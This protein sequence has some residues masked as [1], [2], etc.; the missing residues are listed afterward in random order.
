MYVTSNRGRGGEDPAMMEVE[1]D[2]QDL[3]QTIMG[4]TTQRTGQNRGTMP[5]GPALPGFPSGA[6][7]LPSGAPG[8]LQPQG[9]DGGPFTG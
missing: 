6:P 2:F 9:Q 8:Q 4:I 1:H 7:G 3:V 5:G